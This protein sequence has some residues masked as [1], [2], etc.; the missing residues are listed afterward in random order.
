VEAEAQVGL[1]EKDRADAESVLKLLELGNRSEAIEAERAHLARLQEEERYLEAL[2]GKLPVCSPVPG[3]VVTP[4]L[5]EKVGQY[6]KEGDLIGTVEEPAL[7]E[8]EIGVS[9]QD[10]ARVQPGQAVELKARALPFR[11]F[12]AQVTRIA[13]G[14]QRAEAAPAAGAAPAPHGD[15]YATLTVYS[16][17]DNAAGELRPGMTGYAR[18]RCGDRSFGAIL[19]EHSFRY[20]RTEFWW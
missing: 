17:V 9:E 10:L 5:K 11:T 15:S 16:E 4:H 1:R 13:P 12:D 6:L 18:I 3:L 19:L 20:L 7:L 2:Q 8:V 14:T